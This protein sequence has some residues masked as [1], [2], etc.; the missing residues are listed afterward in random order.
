MSFFTYILQSKKTGHYYIGS[1]ENLS[2]RLRAH[3]AG[4]VRSTRN[5]GPFSIVYTE[6]F[7]TRQDAYRREQEIK[8]YKTGKAF[9]KLLT[10]NYSGVV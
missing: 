3:N 5:R 9:Y 2:D 1:T 7:S 4:K 10:N 8:R 6:E